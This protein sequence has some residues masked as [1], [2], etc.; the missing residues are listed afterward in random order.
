MRH[1]FNIA[2]LCLV[3][4]AC[5]TPKKLKSVIEKSMGAELTI[6]KGAE[7]YASNYS[8]KLPLNIRDTVVVDESLE[9][10][11]LKG[12][13]IIMNAVKDEESGEMIASEQLDAVVVQARFRNIA[14]RNGMVDLAFDITIPEDMQDPHW[15]IRFTPTFFVLEDTLKLDQLFITGKEYRAEQLK[16]YELYNNFINS[17]IPDSADFV[18]SFTHQNMLEIFI[19]RN[20]KELAD[21]RKDSSLVSYS[22]AESIMGVSVQD[23]I[24]HYT[25][26]WLV[27]RNNRR[28]LNKDKMYKK[29]VKSPIITEGVRLDSISDSNGKIVYHYV[30][31]I[32]TRKHLKKVDMVLDG[33]IYQEGK[34]IYTMPTSKPLTF[35]ISSMVAF[36]DNTTRYIKKVIERNAV[37]NTAAYID[38]KKGE[39]TLN[40]TLHNNAEE[41]RRIE[42]NIREVLE[43]RDFL[44]DSLLITASCSP[45][46]SYKLNEKLSASRA[47]SVKNYF[48]NFIVE[49]RDSVANSVWEL[50]LGDSESDSSECKLVKDERGQVVDFMQI[51]ANWVAEEWTRLEQLIRSDT[52]LAE[53]TAL[54][55]IIENT[56]DIDLRE[57]K[58]QSCEDYEYIRGVIYPSL[59]TVKF[60][61]YMHRKG[62]IKD[63]VHTTVVDSVYMSGV[64]ALKDRDYKAAIAKLRPYKDY[65]SAVAFVCLDYNNSA[66]EILEK[67]PR[68]AKRDYMLAVVYSRMGDEAKGVEYYM[69]SCEQDSS[70]RFRGNLDPEVSVLIKKYGIFKEE[71]IEY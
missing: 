7:S 14:E 51:K 55:D 47:E 69:Q 13:T 60:D 48:S 23:A 58:M 44:V 54:L 71:N 59:R 50:E 42:A 6:S 20:F 28:I 10:K 39:A 3:V 15:Q 36:A 70:M 9:I 63:T 5:S 18:H 52:L 64:Q 67:L 8:N 34:S 65:N 68:S 35:Y 33:S 2:M 37:A 38:F 53:R 21:L 61:F 45:E 31:S 1:F 56:E 16:G 12:N 30:Q 27:K 25:K 43:N 24:E 62:M 57:R 4:Y 41:I 19:D 26:G 22:Y 40:D 49:Y 29:Y 17:I 32:K 66:L 11:D 46:G